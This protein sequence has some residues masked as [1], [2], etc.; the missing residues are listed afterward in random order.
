MALM[1][2][3]SLT[4]NLRAG[5]ISSD[6]ADTLVALSKW[7]SLE[8]VQARW[9]RYSISAGAGAYAFRLDR[10]TGETALCRSTGCETPADL[11]RAAGATSAAVA[12][13]QVASKDAAATAPGWHNDPIAGSAS[14]GTYDPWGSDKGGN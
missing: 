14:N 3:C 12:A 7:P 4:A 5:E 11:A 1:S 9:G 2:T 6:G 8:I 10:L 13:A